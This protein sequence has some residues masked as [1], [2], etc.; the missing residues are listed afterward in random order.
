MASFN[1]IVIVGYLGRD[2]EIRYMPDGTAV[3]N[4]SVATTEKKKD[5]SGEAQ[6][7][8]T[9]FRINVWGKQAEAA[10][11]YLSK[12]RQVYVEGRLSQ[13]EYTDRDGNRRSSLDVRATDVQFLG[14]R[15]EEGSSSY[16]Q[17]HPASGANPNQPADSGE[18]D[19]HV[20]F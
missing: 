2:P 9:W 14:P 16:Q 18:P 19:D 15:G 12:G 3:C 7:V 5:R 10:N 6:D 8:T 11:Q 17:S 1:K 13:Q 20:P 4:F